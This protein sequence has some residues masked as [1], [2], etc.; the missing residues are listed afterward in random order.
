MDNASHRVELSRR[1]LLKGAAA[2]G[3]AAFLTACAG[4]GRGGG[5]DKGEVVVLGWQT[6]LTNE[7]IQR[8]QQDTGIRLRAVVADSDQSM[9]SKVKAGG[10]AQYDVVW[11]NCGF[12][13]VYQDSDLIEPFDPSE[14]A[15]SAELY[16][17]FLE[18]PAFPYLADAGKV[19]MLPNAWAA[20]GFAWNSQ[21][22]WQPT[23]PLSWNQLWDVPE[24]RVNMHGSGEDLLAIAGLANGVPRDEIYSMSGSTLEAASAKLRD[25]RPFLLNLQLADPITA[26]RLASQEAFASLTSSFGVVFAGN[27]EYFGGEE[28]IKVAVPE[29]GTVGWVDGMQLVKGAKNRDNA[30]VFMDWWMGSEWNQDRLWNEMFFASCN[31]V[32]TERILANGG[33]GA[34]T[35]T[36]L[37]GDQPELATQI[38]F[39]R[40]PDDPSA[41]A[42]A[43]DQAMA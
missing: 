3:G 37:Q 24:G 2:L 35:M 31:K 39:Q 11:A 34:K 38:A 6:Y 23:E 15:A 4:G 29:E 20:N 21:A 30:F 7:I 25:L 33:Q 12:S 28:V 10:S 19:F 41:W 17:T 1:T 27:D 22:P 14:I 40:P 13:P 32:T 36:T 43:Y 9:F 26:Q 18:D 5:G 8:F 42:A 16:P